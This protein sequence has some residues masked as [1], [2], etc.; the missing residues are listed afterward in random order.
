MTSSDQGAA[1]RS[2]KRKRSGPNFGTVL[3][4]AFW[5]YLAGFFTTAMLDKPDA[6]HVAALVG[7]A[8]FLI[9]YLVSVR[10]LFV[11]EQSDS[12]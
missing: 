5:A 2:A 9:V 4:L 11:T 12:L 10:K 6:K 8:I 1:V 3:S 7:S